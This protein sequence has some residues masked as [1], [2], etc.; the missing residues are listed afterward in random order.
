[1]IYL[2]SPYTD[3]V[4]AV[5][6]GRYVDVCRVAAKMMEEGQVVFCP[7]AHTHAIGSFMKK[8]LK[9]NVDFWMKI[10]LPFLKNCSHLVVLQM[11]G[12]DK[13][14]GVK[15]EIEFAQENKIPIIYRAF[16]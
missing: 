8:D 4:D 14:A 3:P 15:K 12:W 13:S 9:F 11:P 7:I 6:L 2:A 10:D 1:M 5:R 16:P